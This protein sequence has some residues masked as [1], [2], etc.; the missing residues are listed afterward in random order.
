MKEIAAK[1]NPE[2]HEEFKWNHTTKVKY[3]RNNR[4]GNFIEG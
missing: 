2:L 3:K 1:I 4:K